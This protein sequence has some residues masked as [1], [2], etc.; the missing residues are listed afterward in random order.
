ML[1]DQLAQNQTFYAARSRPSQ[2]FHKEVVFT[3]FGKINKKPRR[4]ERDFL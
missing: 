4:L 1:R 3:N 2:V